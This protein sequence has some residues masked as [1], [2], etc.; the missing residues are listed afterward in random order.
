QKTAALETLFGKDAMSA[1]G[2]LVEEGSDSLGDFSTQLENST[3]T[4]KEM[5]ET[6]EG[7]MGGALRSLKSSLEELSLSFFEM[8]EGPLT[9]IINKFTELIDWFSGLSDETKQVIM[10]VLGL[11]AAI[12]PL[13]IIIGSV[14]SAI[15]KIKTA[16]KGVGEVIKGVG[17]AFN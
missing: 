8:G 1:F 9:S 5:H 14:I 17:A 12:G 2:I 7:G 3:G 13:L 4:A 16:I 15:V 10:V 11:V 6:M